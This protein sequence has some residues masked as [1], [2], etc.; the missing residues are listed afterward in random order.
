M[1]KTVLSLKTD[2]DITYNSLCHALVVHLSSDD[3]LSRMM[4]TFLS[5]H[6][7][8]FAGSRPFDPACNMKS[9]LTSMF[10]LLLELLSIKPSKCQDEITS[11]VPVASNQLAEFASDKLRKI[12]SLCKDFEAQLKCFRLSKAFWLV[13]QPRMNLHGLLGPVMADLFT[14]LSSLLDNSGDY[15]RL[16]SVLTTE[17]PP[18]GKFSFGCWSQNY[19]I[20]PSKHPWVLGIAGKNGGGLLQLYMYVYM[21]KVSD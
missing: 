10:D 3:I 16:T 12:A 20:V 13:K 18:A 1:C 11:L 17:D 2:D 14:F 21:E 15:P 19:R 4:T 6:F 5:L 9:C 7:I 8:A